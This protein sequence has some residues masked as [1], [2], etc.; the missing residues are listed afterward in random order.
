MRGA[1]L[2]GMDRL[3]VPY[4]QTSFNIMLAGAIIGA[5]IG[6]VIRHR[7]SQKQSQARSNH[8]NRTG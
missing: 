8:S 3:V 1:G 5:V 6:V 4:A 2:K 7:I